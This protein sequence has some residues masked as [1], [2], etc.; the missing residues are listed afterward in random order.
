MIPSPPRISR[1]VVYIS[2]TTAW[3]ASSDRWTSGIILTFPVPLP[4]QVR[5]K[6]RVE[7][8]EQHEDGW[9]LC[10]APNGDEGLVPM[11]FLQLQHT[12]LAAA[13]SIRCRV[14]HS[15]NAENDGDLSL[16][17][18]D[19]VTVTHRD[20]SGWWT[21]VDNAGREGVFPMNF[22]R[23]EAEADAG[24]GKKPAARDSETSEEGVGAVHRVGNSI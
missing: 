22:V 23:V 10:R 1:F 15:F 14:M 7:V 17:M 24:G 4:S 6:D 8:V 3:S 16:A 21:G 11:N 13:E 18:G 5:K 12:E 2:R 19:L 20:D 9:W